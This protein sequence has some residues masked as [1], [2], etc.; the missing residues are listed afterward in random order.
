MVFSDLTRFPSFRAGATQ[1]NG[2]QTSSFGW[3]TRG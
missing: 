2:L 3:R 1:E